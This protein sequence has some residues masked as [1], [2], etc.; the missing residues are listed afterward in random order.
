MACAALLTTSCDM[1]TIEPG[2][3]GEDQ[4]IDNVTNA[5]YFRNYLYSSLRGL[6]TGSPVYG[7]E[8]QM[9]QFIGIAT[10]GNRG[11]EYSNGVINSSNS[12]ISSMYTGCYSRISEAHY[13]IEKV[14]ALIDGG[15]LTDTEKVEAERYL[16]EAYFVR[17][18]CY[19]FLLDHYTDPSVIAT[20]GDEPA[21]GLQIVTIYDPTGDTSKYPGRSTLNE[22][23]AQIKS[24]LDKAYKGLKAYEDAG[25]LENCVA[26]APYLSSYAAEALEARVAL[27][28]GD[29]E[30]AIAKAQAV[31]ANNNY[32]LASGR[33]YIDMWA[34][35]NVDELIFA[36]FVNQNE[37]GTIASTCQGWNYWWAGDP[38]QVDYIP[39]EETLFEYYD[40]NDIRIAAFFEERKINTTDGATGAYVFVKYPGVASLS[41]G[42]NMYLNAPKP[43][44]LSE[45]YLILAEA[46]AELNQDQV[47][48]AAL[49]AIR[50][51]RIPGYTYT[52]Y[53]GSELIDQVRTE[54]SMELLGEGFRMSDLRRWKVAW[55]RNT[56]YDNMNPLVTPSLAPVG[57][58]VAYSATDYRYVWPI[59]A[60]EMEI[61]P[62]LA[63]QQNPNY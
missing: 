4:A 39:T 5:K 17:A 38:Y 58:A 12:G 50:T 47:A 63:G 41:S 62:Q 60:S 22:S 34:D 55:N 57:L 35:T 56:T 31:I 20:K 1:D 54:R 36:P 43:F 28:T 7:V 29:Y 11:G 21:K 52:S 49:K 23:V 6:S 46:A 42:T 40:D 18:Y 24:D 10:N 25:N 26:G 27:I 8:L 33:N 13:F 61:N 37:S 3:L 15:A 14:Q 59:P 51:A 53:T 16:A 48:N 19:A 45:Q 32:S 44:R 2:V 30:T 9:D